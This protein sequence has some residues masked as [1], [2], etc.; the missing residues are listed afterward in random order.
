MNYLPL[1]NIFKGRVPLSL[2]SYEKQKL[3]KS[4]SNG[5]QQ[6]DDGEH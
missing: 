5:C 4:L 3:N 6:A 2:P 1:K